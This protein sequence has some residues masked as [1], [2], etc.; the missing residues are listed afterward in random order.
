M[1]DNERITE[2]ENQ[3]PEENTATM[4]HTQPLDHT[5]EVEPIEAKPDEAQPVQANA[6]AVKKLPAK[7]LAIIG[8]AVIAVI[9]VILFVV[10]GLPAIRYSNGVKAFDSK[11]YHRAA[12]IF[13]KLDDYKDS[14][15][16]LKQANMAI[17]YADAVEAYNNGDYSRA[18]ELFATLD[19]YKDSKTYR[20]QADLGIHYT[21]ANA[22]VQEGKYDEAI[23]EYINAKNFQDAKTL[24]L[25]TYDLQGETLFKDKQYAKAAEAFSNAGNNARVLDCGVALVEEQNDYSTALTVLK[26][27]TSEKAQLYLNYANGM[28]SMESEDYQAAIGF[29]ANST[30]LLDT[31][32]RAVEATFQ[33]AEKCLREGYL[34]K[35]KSLYDSLPE[36][37]AQG[38]ITAAD[39]IALL[40]KNKKLL[41]LV[42][43]WNATDTY[44]K[45]QADSTTSSYYYYWYQDS[46]K[47]GTVTVTCPYNDADGTFT[48][49]GTATFPSYQN[50]SSNSSKL[51]T[52][53]ESFTFSTTS[54]GTIPYQIGSSRTTKLSFSGNMFDL[55]YKYVN[56]S[57]NVYWHYTF[58]SKVKYGSRTMLA[59]DR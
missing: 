24:L 44:Y 36:D 57:S 40:N 2:P 49:K 9:A 13:S 22:K 53:M 11:D 10:Y 32:T 25:Q 45:V 43:N 1:A 15:S 55:Q 29:F 26:N 17:D 37:Y 38:E 54:T 19:D 33:L 47:L 18:A 56:E 3:S 52:D 21:N 5:A 4:E 28:L 8:A 50:F 34:N 42:G 35:A 48:I 30:G 41:D 27:D 39:R 23:K 46:I 59:E 16:Y 6:T 14:D 20:K 7:K 31:D 51:R 58:T 12:E